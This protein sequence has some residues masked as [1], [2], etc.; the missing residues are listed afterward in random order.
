MLAESQPCLSLNVLYAQPYDPAAA[1]FRFSDY[2][3]FLVKAKKCPAEEFQIIF[4]DGPDGDLYRAAG[5]DQSTLNWLEDLE[6]VPE[7]EKPAVF[8]FLDNGMVADIGD[9]IAKSDEVCLYRGHLQD[10]AQDLWDEYYAHEIPDPCRCISILKPS[11]G[12]SGWVGICPGTN[13]SA[14]KRKS[15]RM[16]KGNPYV[17]RLLCEFAHAASRTESAFKAKFQGL[18][19][20][21]MAIQAHGVAPW[22]AAP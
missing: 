7:D 9:A 2:E 17:R 1:G 13:E 18:A 8:F 11:L 15:G 5:L 3:D 4:I 10:A 22:L 6:L 19:V 16:R 21:R 14:G 12:T 20:H